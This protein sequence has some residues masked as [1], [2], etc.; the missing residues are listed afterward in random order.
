MTDTLSNVS[1]AEDLKE[2]LKSDDDEEEQIQVFG[3]TEETILTD[4]YTN[5][6]VDNTEQTVR[7]EDA[8]N[9]RDVKDEDA[10]TTYDVKDEDA[11]NSYDST[12]KVDDP[13]VG[14]IPIIAVTK[15]SSSSSSSSSSDSGKEDLKSKKK[16]KHYIKKLK[17]EN[18]EVSDKL[19]EEIA[20]TAVRKFET[21][22]VCIVNDMYFLLYFYIVYLVFFIH[23]LFFTWV[24]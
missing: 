22:F 9:T 18:K 20:I 5:V 1:F 10:F 21:Y 8:F 7:D 19:K 11:L 13:S 3:V 17:E 12:N 14:S 15:S 4:E 2:D 24:T 6:S 16:R 23:S